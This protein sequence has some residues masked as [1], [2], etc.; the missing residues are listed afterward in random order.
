MSS[1]HPL[2]I[3]KWGMTM[4]EGTLVGWLVAEGSEV[5]AGDAVASVESSKIAGDLEAVESGILRR[6]LAQE[7]ETHPV[8]TLVGVIA[9]ADVSDS[10]VQD[11]I[12]A[13]VGA[14]PA[15]DD[16]GKAEE[17]GPAESVGASEDGSRDLAPT[18]STK[19][20]SSTPAAPAAPTAPAGGS[21]DVDDVR[22]PERFR[23]RD[24]SPVPA[25]PHASRLAERMGIMLA[26][27]TPTARGGRVSVQDVQKAI[28]AEGGHVAFGNDR[29]R[30]GRV[31]VRADDSQVAATPIA[32]RLAAEHGVNLHE[33]RPS[34]RADRVTRS[35]VLGHVARFSSG[36]AAESLSAGDPAP[37]ASGKQENPVHREPMSAMRKVI[38]GR[39]QE[40]YQQ[41]PH[42]RV[43][44]HAQIDALLAIRAEVNEHRDD[45]RLTVNDL[46]L[47]AAAQALVA[48]PGINAQYD[49]ATETIM[50]FE[51]VDLSVA[52]STDEGL[53]TPIVRGADQMKVTEISAEVTDLATR[54]KAGTLTPEEFQGGT[55]TVSNLGMFGI[56]DFDAIIN[57]PQVAILAVGGGSREFVPDDDGAPVLRTLLPLTLSSDH[58]VIDGAMAARYC[59]ELKRLLETPSLIFA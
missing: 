39:L 30:V 14:A 44:T 58:R 2:E 48:V 53:I 24:E 31:G 45:A 56:S 50:R 10:E 26:G 4:D 55:F 28:A 16:S 25:T 33:I 57:P 3:P 9:D 36:G 15:P 27:I 11:Y 20:T 6:V 38:A 13:R 40:S 18:T 8:G 59:S 41:S 22:I 51:H 37:S 21:G 46:V 34:G 32:R 17:T 19:G 43:T 29:P 35:D 1:I 23:G 47:A 7:G 49:S 12:D 42:F 52:V 54:A 5:S